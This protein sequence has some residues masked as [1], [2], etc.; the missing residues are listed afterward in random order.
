MDNV[1]TT[2]AWMACDIWCNEF[3]IS[4][5]V[6]ETHPI[7]VSLFVHVEVDDYY[8]YYYYGKKKQTKLNGERI[9]GEL[10]GECELWV[11]RVRAQTTC[12]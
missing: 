12:W 1:H 6:L 9:G 10:A 7:F 3:G 11:H 8:Y 2:L 4:L 5:R